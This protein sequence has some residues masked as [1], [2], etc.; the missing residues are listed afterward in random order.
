MTEQYEVRLGLRLYHRV[1]SWDSFSQVEFDVLQGLLREFGLDAIF[2]NSACVVDKV[3]ATNRGS[4]LQID[5]WVKIR[6]D[7]IFLTL[8]IMG[9]KLFVLH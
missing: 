6:T 8:R 1:L 3:I 7:W 5:F 2:G 9:D 4:A